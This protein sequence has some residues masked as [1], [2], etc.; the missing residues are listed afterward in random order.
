MLLEVRRSEKARWPFGG[1]FKFNY[2]N[3]S[4]PR[5]FKSTLVK[6]FFRHKELILI[7]LEHEA[8]KTAAHLAIFPGFAGSA[9]GCARLLVTS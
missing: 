9:V 7:S 5:L 2:R 8:R 4:F 3:H 1:Y 6:P